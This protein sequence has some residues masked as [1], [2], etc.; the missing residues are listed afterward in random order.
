M[1]FWA[2]TDRRTAAVGRGERPDPAV[3][4]AFLEGGR[5]VCRKGERGGEEGEKGE[6]GGEELHFGARVFWC[7]K[8]DGWK[9]G[10][11]C[12]TRWYWS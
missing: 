9:V 12:L 10:N 8:V 6:E 3:V 1:E 5:V 2:G 7:G 4:V 11:G